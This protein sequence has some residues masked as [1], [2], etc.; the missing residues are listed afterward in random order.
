[1]IFCITDLRSFPDDEFETE[2]NTCWHLRG[3]RHLAAYVMHPPTA[4]PVTTQK[5]AKRKRSLRRD[6]S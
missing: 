4:L 1:M 2:G 6:T 3:E 5:V